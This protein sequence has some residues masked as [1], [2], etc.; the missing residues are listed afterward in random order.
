ME[1]ANF[2]SL[3]AII[4]KRANL[5]ISTILAIMKQLL[6]GLLL[7]HQH[8]IVHKNIKAQNILLQSPPD[9]GRVSIIMEKGAEYNKAEGKWFG[10]GT[11]ANVY[12]ELIKRFAPNPLRIGVYVCE[13]GLNTIYIV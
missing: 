7:L 10:P 12:T 3:D 9:S 4:E 1:Y 2:S 11:V 5:T 8:D 13:Q 6:Q